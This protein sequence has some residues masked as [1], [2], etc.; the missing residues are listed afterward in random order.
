MVSTIY[1]HCPQQTEQLIK[2]RTFNYIQKFLIVLDSPS[3][4]VMQ[5]K[6]FQFVIEQ[7][8]Q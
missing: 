8:K 2:G 5:K 4:Y 7:M 3:C 1:L 6:C